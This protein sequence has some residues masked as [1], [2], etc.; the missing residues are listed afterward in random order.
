MVCK[1]KED[2]KNNTKNNVSTETIKIG[3]IGQTQYSISILNLI[4]IPKIE[5]QI[6]HT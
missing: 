1:K 6:Y 4:K 2:V 3:F 5:E